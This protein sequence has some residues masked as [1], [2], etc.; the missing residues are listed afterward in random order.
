MGASESYDVIVVG[1]GP[2]GARAAFHAAR[3]GLRVCLIERK[4][5]VGFPVR[6]GEG[7]GSK[8]LSKDLSIDDSW[9][10]T[11]IR[12]VRMISPS[13]IRVEL[14]KI[15]ESYV[16]DREVM[17]EA[18]VREAV[19][20]G[21]SYFPGTSVVSVEHP[22]RGEYICH[23]PDRDFSTECVVLA[24]GVESRLARDLGWNTTL[25]LEDVE[26]CAFCRVAHDSIE[27]DLIEFYTGSRIAPGGY[28]WVMPRGSGRANVGLGILGIHSSPGKAMALLDKFL[29]E[30]F[31]GGGIS[32][33]HC[34]GVPVGKWLR[35]LVRDGAMIVGDAARQVNSLNGGGIEYALY[36][37]RIAGETIAE[38]R[39]R[40]GIDVG[41]LKSY[42]KKW[43]VDSGK[44]QMR[45][46]ALKSVLLRKDD[47]FYDRIARSL[48]HAEPNSLSYM[49]V[50][51]RTFLRR[52][53]LLPK[54]FR[55]F[56]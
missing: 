12:R 45:T 54:V 5:H 4:E 22:R 40:S 38:A 27:N 3:G 35:P 33:I 23:A 56:R 52:P 25:S 49:R 46:Y 9:I 13:G 15:G 47:S 20:S 37:G 21:V 51:V 17:D 43:A 34:G 7:L 32:H 26:C 28:A 50:F 16:V 42:Q 48:E 39:G 19:S 30:H 44:Q 14:H 24:D 55:F 10:R 2:A 29:Q 8:G 53:W 18:L 1:A 11:T 36:A 41:R 31:P 6:C